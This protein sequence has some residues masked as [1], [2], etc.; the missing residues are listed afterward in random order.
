MLCILL[1]LYYYYCCI[2]EPVFFFFFRRQFREIIPSTLSTIRSR[3]YIAKSSSPIP[4]FRH[5]LR[6]SNTSDV[7]VIYETFCLAF[8]YYLRTRRN[9]KDHLG[10]SHSNNELIYVRFTYLAFETSHFTVYVQCYIVRM[11]MLTGGSVCNTEETY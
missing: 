5:T 11:R 2:L 8:R 4:L 1:L 9:N 10:G 7:H 3:V 6:T